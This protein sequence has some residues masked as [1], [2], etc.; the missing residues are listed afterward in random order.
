MITMN[1]VKTMSPGAQLLCVIQNLLHFFYYL[2]TIVTFSLKMTFALTKFVNVFMEFRNRKQFNP[3]SLFR[4]RLV[5][6]KISNK[7]YI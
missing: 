2:I 3:V 1:F 4:K 5:C 6:I 7:L